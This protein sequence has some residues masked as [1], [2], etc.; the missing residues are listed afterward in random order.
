MKV[1]Y[2]YPFPISDKVIV[3]LPYN[4]RV[5]TVQIQDREAVL[6]AIVDADEKSFGDRTF[7]VFGTGNPMPGYVV[8]HLKHLTTIQQNNG[9][10]WHIFE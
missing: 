1:I 10:V 3:R 7:Y 8:E 9:L 4:S 5:L 6:W 2:K